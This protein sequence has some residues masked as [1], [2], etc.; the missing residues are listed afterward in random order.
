MIRRATHTIARL[1]LWTAVAA[2][3]VAAACLHREEDA[4]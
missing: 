4:R 1:A 2:L 3:V